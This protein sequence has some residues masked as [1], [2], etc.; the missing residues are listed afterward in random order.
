[1]GATPLYGVQGSTFD[2]GLLDC[3]MFNAQRST[4]NA[5]G[6]THHA[7]RLHAL[8]VLCVAIF[9]PILSLMTTIK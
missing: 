9:L 1:M 5:Q 2:V 7:P 8:R 6:I 3:W 4:L